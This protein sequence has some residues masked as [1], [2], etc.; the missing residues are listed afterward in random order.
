MAS[1]KRRPPH[2]PTYEQLLLFPE[3]AE[4]LIDDRFETYQVSVAHWSGLAASFR[5]AFE[6]VHER[7]SARVL[8]VHGA[9]GHGKSLFVQTLERAF[10]Q[11]ERSTV[12]DEKNLW[13][14]LTGGPDGPLETVQ[15]VRKNTSLR[16]VSPSDKWL[17]EERAFAKSDTHGVRIFLFDD[18]QKDAFVREWAG[19]TAGEYARLRAE[20]HRKTVLETVAERIVEDCRG[21]F[22][23]SIFVLLSND[24]V[25]L[26]DLKA[27]LDLSHRGLAQRIELPLPEASVKE[28]IVR[29][30]TNLLNPRSY[31]FCLDRGGREEKREAHTM[32]TGNRGFIDCFQAINRALTAQSREGRSGRPANKNLLTLVTLGTSPAE[33]A[34]FMADHEFEHDSTV[35]HE[36]IGVWWCRKRWASGLTSKEADYSRRASLVESEFALRWVALDMTAAWVLCEAGEDDPLAT[37]IVDLLRT[38]PSIAKQKRAKADDVE[39]MAKAL[40]ARKDDPALATFS[41]KFRPLGQQR[42]QVYE[43]PIAQR[44]GKRLSHGLKVRG[45]LKPDVILEEYEPCAVTRATSTEDRAIEVAIKRGC[46]VLELTAHLQ[47]DMRGLEAY[48]ADKVCVYADLLESV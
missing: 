5:E 25:Y 9:Q 46:H 35:T 37:Q 38:M 2:A 7:R 6:T 24:P 16:R 34:S 23:R 40:A 4:F 8:L 29:T 30:N 3:R 47:A 18:A 11:S 45:T 19:L 43:A 17:P 32:L 22:A 1:H 41:E 31:W 28:E 20:G 27:H 10:Q 14:L 44:L 42:S 33:V 39:E 26:D 13:H 15:S 21:A 36:Q 48:L 12:F